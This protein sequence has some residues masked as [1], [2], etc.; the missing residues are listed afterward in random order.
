MHC[1]FLGV[2]LNSMGPFTN[3]V[4]SKGGGKKRDEILS[5]TGHDG[6]DGRTDMK[7]EKVM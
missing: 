7:V 1:Y 4:C 2:F 5:V 3:Y 6:K